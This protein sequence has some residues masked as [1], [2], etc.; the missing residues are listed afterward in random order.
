MHP[1]QRNI[2]TLLTTLQQYS[3]FCSPSHISSL[4]S[5]SKELDK[6]IEIAEQEGRNLRV[7]VVGQMKAGKS[8]FLN[9]LLFSVDILPKAATPM[10]AA[11]TRIAYADSTYAEIEF[12]SVT[13]WQGITQ[14][15]K[16]YQRQYQDIE[17]RLIAERKEKAAK[18]LFGS[19]MKMPKLTSSN[20][21]NETISPTEVQRYISEE[22]R[23]CHELVELAKQLDL[24]QYLGKKQRI[25]GDDLAKLADQLGDYVGSAGRFTAITKM[26]SLY[27]NDERLKDIEIYDTPGFNDPVVSRGTQTRQFLGQCDV[28]FLLSAI[29]QFLTKSDLGLLREQLSAAGIDSKA[30]H[31]VG[32]QRDLVFR[33]DRELLTQARLLAQQ[34]PAE[35]RSQATIGAMMQL[36]DKKAIKM[37]NDAISAH[38]SDPK[39]DESTQQILQRIQ[40]E[41]PLLVSAL[42]WRIAEHLHDLPPDLAEQYDG[43]CRDT[44]FQFSEAALRSFSNIPKLRETMGQQRLQKQALLQVKV[45]NLHQGAYT[46]CQQ[47]QREVLQQID[48][49]LE[50]LNTTNIAQLQR[51]QDLFKLKLSNGRKSI[52]QTLQIEANE[53]RHKIDFLTLDIKAGQQEFT[54]ID[55]LEEKETKIERREKSGFFAGLARFFGTG[56]YQNHTIEIVTPYAK[57][58]DSIEQINLFADDAMISLQKSLTTI[59]DMQK[60]RK[61]VASTAIDLFDTE[62]PDFDLLSFKV[63]V[64]GCLSS[65]QPP[66]LSFSADDVINDIVAR[67]GSGS[68]KQNDIDQLKQAHQKAI[69]DVSAHVVKLAEQAKKDID[70][71]FAN[72]EENLVT[73]LIGQ[74][75]NDLDAMTSQLSDKE[76]SLRSL[77]AFRESIMA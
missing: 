1:T 43:L 58:Q 4:S 27:V 59:I 76:N 19:I 77:N 30:V 60:L 14:N 48:S 56:G 29:N 36:L 69:R 32:S 8:S 20:P 31:V 24:K 22:L 40:Q 66:Q 52:E 71:Y 41:P 68:V 5:L 26:F 9:A 65:Y 74:L 35:Q 63:Q 46:H 33:M 10:T 16:E 38:L 49:R 17:Q 64:N 45:D 61:R 13:D 62:D 39:I 55:T 6:N 73:N 28:V 72:M 37:A 23:S 25:D 18:P 75:Q 57:V 21:A 15:A 50:Q 53:I 34:V 11:L 2:N 47:V 42:C 54:N 3:Q 12:Y 44:Q 51:R 67:F 70:E 7:A